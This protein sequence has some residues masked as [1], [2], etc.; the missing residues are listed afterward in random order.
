MRQTDHATDTV[1]RRRKL[2]IHDYYRM[3]DAGIIGEHERVELIDGEVIDMVPIGSDHIGSVNGLTEMLVTATV[4]RAIISVQNPVVLDEYN[5]AEPD[6]AVLRFPEDRYR[7]AKPGPADILLLIEVAKSSVR[8]DR[9]VKVPL[10]ARAGIAKFWIADITRRVS[11]MYSAPEGGGYRTSK[12]YGPTDT[13]ALSE[14]P[15]VRVALSLVFS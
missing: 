2:T 13:V 1:L 5:E 6:F 12:T 11:E 7:D 15:D 14:L 4:G 10:Y 8:Y 9:T 3:G